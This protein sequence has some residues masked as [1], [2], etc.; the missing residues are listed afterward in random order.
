MD[1]IRKA[2]V[3]LRPSPLRQEKLLEQYYDRFQE[4]ALSLTRGD[5]SKAQD[6]VHDLCLHLTLSQPDPAKIENLDGYLYSALRHVY[7]SSLSRSTREALRSVSLDEF[8]SIHIAFRAPA[9]GDP[10]QQQNDLR[11]ICAYA[12]WRK[13][14]AKSASYFILRFFHGYYRREIATIAGVSLSTVDPQLTKLR[15]EVHLYLSQPGKLQFTSREAPPDPALKWSL[16]SSLELFNELRETI[17]A[18]REGDCLPEEKLLAHYRTGTSAPISC[19]LLS[20]IV[21]CER[22]LSLIDLHFRR[23]TLKDRESLDSVGH[24]PEDNSSEPT[25]MQALTCEAML[26]FVRKYS[27]EIIEHRPRILSIAVDGKILASHGVQSSTSTL[28][29]RIEHPESTSFVEVFSEQG[30][31]LAL[32]SILELPPG[33]PHEQIQRITLNDDRW[34]ELSLT[35]DGLGLNSEVTYFDPALATQTTEEGA[36]EVPAPI[37]GYRSRVLD[38]IS[39]YAHRLPAVLTSLLRRGEQNPPAHARLRALFR[40]PNITGIAMNPVF[41]SLLIVACA[42]GLL[43]RVWHRPATNRVSASQLLSRAENS[44]LTVMHGKPGVV[45]QKVRITTSHIRVESEIYRDVQGK[46]RRHTDQSGGE[47]MAQARAALASVGLDPDNPLSALSYQAWHDSQEMKIDT[48]SSEGNGLLTLTTKVPNGGIRQEELIV[49]ATDFHPVLRKIETANDGDIEVAELNYAVLDWSG[50]NE[51]L[52]ETP[53]LPRTINPVLL[54]S[55]PPSPLMMDTAE[56]SARLVIHRLHADEGEQVEV[57]RTDWAVEVTGVVDTEDRKQ[58]LNVALRALPHVRPEVLSVSDLTRQQR[59]AVA[60]QTAAVQAMDAPDS[61]LAAYLD[62]DAG[63]RNALSGTS[64]QLLDASLR[65]RSSAN[66]ITT[67]QA[68]FSV[69]GESVTANEALLKLTQSYTERLKDGLALEVSVLQSLGFTPPPPPADMERMEDIAGEAAKNNA[70]CLEL[71]TSGDVV[72]R[73]ATQIVPEVYASI[74][75]IRAALALQDH[76]KSRG[77]Q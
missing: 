21:S 45:Y 25:K 15:S 76:P 44:E 23:P 67:L 35:F 77:E 20:H 74:D 40:L 46:R 34:L 58:E 1:P 63:K 38:W 4:W 19:S 22:C 7:L 10:L 36:P 29:A 12:I 42:V 6:I 51:A 48:V 66:E 9:S 57:K 41:A 5:E 49:R 37:S 75:R 39:N 28:C 60:P 64:R 56:L 73:P 27:N 68:R 43:L 32:L 55:A 59:A 54:P 2:K 61:S 53:S 30:I 72:G 47:K 8:D 33:G 14:Q 52:F 11:R 24:T 16:L 65:V 70:L 18:A 62:G 69:P 3:L 13:D 71:I 26:R 50:V 31:R 17:L